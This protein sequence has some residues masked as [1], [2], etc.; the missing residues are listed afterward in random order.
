MPD[1]ISL[2]FQLRRETSGIPAKLPAGRQ[3]QLNLLDSGYRINS[4]AG[5]TGMM[6]YKGLQTCKYCAR[7][8]T[9]DIK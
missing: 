3:K 8:A 1:L 6:F 5:S 9:R 2:R 4:R 7:Y